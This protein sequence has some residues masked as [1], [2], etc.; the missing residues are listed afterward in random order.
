V[1]VFVDW[2]AELFAKDKLHLTT[3]STVQNCAT[4]Q[5]V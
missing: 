4:T 5:P 1:R 2:L 3:T